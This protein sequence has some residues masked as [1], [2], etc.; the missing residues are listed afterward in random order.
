MKKVLAL[1][2]LMA[3]IGMAASASAQDR[4]WDVRLAWDPNTEPDLAKYSLY[5]NGAKVLDIPAGTEEAVRTV[6]A[7]TYS[8]FLTAS[9]T[10]LNESEPSNT[11]GLTLDTVPPSLEGINLTISIS[12]HVQP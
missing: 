6:P 4:T 9:D 2:V 12:I 10:S 7:G 5:E 8:W 1:A 11:V 3:A